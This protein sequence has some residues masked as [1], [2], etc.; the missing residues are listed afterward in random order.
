MKKYDDQLEKIAQ[1]LENQISQIEKVR[2]ILSWF[3]IQR[4]GRAKAIS[5][6]SKAL[7]KYKLTTIPNWEDVHIDADVKFELTTNVNIKEIAYSDPSHKVERLDSANQGQSLVSVKRDDSLS[8]AITLMLI[9]DFSQLPVMQGDRNPEGFINWKTIGERLALCEEDKSCNLKVSDFMEKD[10]IVIPKNETIF[11]AIEQ[12]SKYDFLLVKDPTNGK[13]TGIITAHDL[14]DQFKLL[15]K[16]FLLISEIENGLRQLINKARFLLPE[17]QEARH[18]DK[19][20]N[21][22]GIADLTFGEYKNLLAKPE[23]WT[24]LNLKLDRVEFIKKLEKIRDLRND[25]MHFDPDGLEEKDIEILEE[26]A[27][28]LRALRNLNLDKVI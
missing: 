22:E 12:I 17:L 1:N 28:F 15:A 20:R 10:I 4:R 2:T 13:I 18:G 21:V 25:I 19:S 23:N 9:N 5:R 26:F 27:Y 16:P 14:N 6:I 3:G 7:E 24:K 11:N 8:K